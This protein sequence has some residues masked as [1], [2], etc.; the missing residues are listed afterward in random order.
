MAWQHDRRSRQARG[1]GRR[2]ERLRA[3]ALTR[4]KHLCQPCKRA[5]RVAPATEVDH[6]VP[7]AKGG[8]DTLENTQSICGPCHKAKTAREA[9]EA[10][11][12]TVRQRRRIGLDG[13]PLDD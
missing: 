3:A 8:A 2:W 1:Y 11:G 13:Y 7:K 10:Q 9:A 5:G 4:D 6:I 12:R